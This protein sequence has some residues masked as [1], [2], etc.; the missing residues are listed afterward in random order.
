MLDAHHNH[1]AE[2]FLQLLRAGKYPHTAAVCYFREI[3]CQI[4]SV[5]GKTGASEIELVFDSAEFPET[6]QHWM[7]RVASSIDP[8]IA[9]CV[10]RIAWQTAE[11]A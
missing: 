4:A 10:V 6:S 2:A 3:I 9:K 11:A 1:H 8:S 5:G 7:Q